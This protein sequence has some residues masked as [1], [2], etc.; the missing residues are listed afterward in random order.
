MSPYAP[1]VG[2]LPGGMTPGYG[3]P[4]P[5]S[6]WTFRWTGFLTASLQGS[7]NQRVAPI[8]GQSRTV[9]HV[10]PQTVDEYGSFVGTSTMP[11]QWAMLNFVYGNPYVSANLSLTTWNP[12]DPITYYQIGSQ[13]FINN[14]FLAYSPPPIGGVRVHAQ[15]GYFTNAYGAIGQY[16]PGI[17]TNF[18]VG[19]V[20][21][22]GENLVAEY[23]P[24]DV[25]TLKLEDGIMGN[26]NGMGAINIVRTG[27]NGPVNPIVWPSSWVHHFHAG[28]ERRGNV[29]FRAG[30][31]YL[32]NWS[33]DDR[34]QTT[35][36]N[37]QVRP[38]DE[39]YVKDG[40][41]QTYGAEVSLASSILGYLGGAVSYTRAD[42]AYPVKGIVTF[43]GDGESL[44]NRWFG[45]LT[46]GTGD[47]VAAGINYTASIG[48]IVSYPVP[49]NGDG[50]DLALNAGFVFAESWAP[51]V[52]ALIAT[53]ANDAQ[54]FS[55]RS[56][57][58][59]GADLLYTFLPFMAA[60]FRTD[61]VVP[62][63]NDSQETFTVIAPRLIFKSDWNSRDTVSLIYGKWF[64]G[65]HSHPEA[66]SITPVDARLDDQ[67]FAI[68]AQMWW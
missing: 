65:A 24:S 46:G 53:G 30:L 14:F 55:G 5:T 51:N 19:I 50:P 11:G 34:L 13:Q 43:G 62:N 56:R 25:V 44:T 28:V 6:D 61:V 10:P 47:L 68:N 52:P 67:L 38:I 48:R 18:L 60:G 17:Y 40:R 59:F 33:Q 36:I 21:G 58:K 64:Y 12:S 27:Q 57:Y 42:N 31:H 26:R 29:T 39:T 3:A 15:A 2:G 9:F 49:F 35:L 7:A 63:S 20:R 8:A 45:P 4:T 1:R 54:P 32:T 37:P 23:D 66:S 16:G 22:V 41:I